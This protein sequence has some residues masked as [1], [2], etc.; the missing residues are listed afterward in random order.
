MR[1]TFFAAL[2]GVWGVGPESF[3]QTYQGGI[4][5]AMRD[6]TGVIPGVVVTLIEED[7]SFE[8]TTTT[9]ELGQYAFPNVAPGIY[10]LAATLAS[11]RPYERLGI[12]VGVQRI[13]VVDIRLEVGP[14]EESITVTGDS[15]V[16]E[17][18]T[19]SN[20]SSIEQV[21]MVTLP[22]S[23][24]N[25]FY[26]SITAPNVV[27]SGN[28]QFVRMQDQNASSLLSISGGP[29]RGNNYTLDGVSITDLQNRAVVI[30]S[31]ESIEEVKI[32]VNTYDAEMGRTGGGVFNTLHRRG[33]NGW[34]GSAL[35]QN[36]PVWGQSQLYFE[37]EARQPKADSYY[38]LWGGSTGG[39]IVPDRTFFWASTEGYR[40]SISRN[41]IITLPSAA[42]AQ[43]DFSG[44]DRIVYD[45][46]TTRPDPDN[47]GSYIR[48]PF[49]GNVI[50]PERLNPV[51]LRIAAYLASGPA[52]RNSASANVVDAAQQMSFN[53]T[54]QFHRSLSTSATYLYYDSDEPFPLF[55]GGPYDRNNG[56]LFRQV[57]T[58]A[59]NTTYLS[60]Q[61]SVWTF[62]YG[63]LDF[64]D[65]FRALPF[66]TASL[67]FSERFLGQI[68]EKLFPFVFVGDFY[69]GGTLG[70]EDIRHYA[71]SANATWAKWVGRHTLKLGGD[72]RRVGVDRHVGSAAA[73][74]FQ[75]LQDFTQGPDPR[76]PSP[77]TGD[78]LAALLLGIPSFGAIDVVDSQDLYIDYLAAFVQDD[79][80]LG[81]NLVLNLGLRVEH[82][83]GLK[84][85]NDRQAV[86]FDREAP[87]P[88]QPI[89]GMTLRGGLVYA[90]VDGAQRHQGDPSAIKLG[91]RAGVAWSIDDRTVVRGG[92]GLFWA[93]YQPTFE[94][95]RG[96]QATT[97]YNASHDGGLTPAGTLTD[98]FPQGL[99]RPLGS[100]LG[101][102]TGAGGDVEFA[103]APRESPYVQQYSASVEREL[104][105]GIVV[106]GGYVGSRSERLGLGGPD[107]AG[108]VNINQLHPG[109]QALGPALDELVPNPFFG[110]PIFG[111]LSTSETIPRAQLLRPYPQFDDLLA[112]QV[113]AGRRRYHALVAR[114]EKRYRDDW[115]TRVNYTFSRTDDNIF[116]EG[117]FFSGRFASPLDSTD[118]DR[119]YSRSVTDTPHRLNVS[120]IYELPFGEG[121]KWLDGGG[122]LSELLGNWTVS[123]TGFF[124]SGFPI[125]VFQVA[126][127]TGVFSEIQRPNVVP[128]V[129]PGHEGSTVENLDSYLN[130]AA[131]S[132]ADA[133]TFGDAPR[134]DTRIRTP[135]RMNWD[136]VLQKNERIGSVRASFRVELINV[137]DTPDFRGPII[138]FG[139][140]NFGTIQQVS[141]FPRT[142]QLM[143]RFDW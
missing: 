76:N 35:V 31:M 118:L 37:K 100:S 62:R 32:Q 110:N 60:G 13:V 18:A 47:P 109:L 21:E 52:G 3:G 135:S 45:P 10:R 36:R 90:G 104:G 7:T 43:G 131:W 65:D 81:E 121:K 86:G 143:L 11:F 130:P 112:H 1:A 12:E 54:H 139:A 105:N 91:P 73:G 126:F 94:D 67:G 125:S 29:S 23:S 20:S 24:R 77:G 14:I 92:F 119:E 6:A 106:S 70:N 16:L 71:H 141:G 5:G 44:S 30:P 34:H 9:N 137:F 22:T 38:W 124:Q 111:N 115:S 116:G 17:M 48:D 53:L 26:L 15:P 33:S 97:F 129:D 79:W 49:P 93:P 66:D 63:F 69:P 75:F 78:P 114:L 128:G 61:D 39:A 113:S 134:T 122:V 117:N 64:D 89:S 28:P 46:L 142:L 136:L 8:R 74:S 2:L 138:A 4:R 88:V 103:D 140:R 87:W 95:P 56:E 85:K 98:P 108:L 42:M 55:L 82:E 50:P 107:S 102:L 25:P 40:S 99:E 123:A 80:R 101:L 127:N 59:L 58:L 83:A 72:Y 96:Y 27:P 120:G 132:L 51:G 68:S 133:F 19:A 41:Q 57:N 84:E